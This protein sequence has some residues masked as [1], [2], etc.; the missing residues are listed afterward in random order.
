MGTTFANES[1]TLSAKVTDTVSKVHFDDGQFVEAGD[2]L[3]ELTDQEETALLAEANA[4]LADA[5]RQHARLADLLTKRS[6]PVSQVD[7]ALARVDAAEARYQSI[8]ARL[9]DRLVTAPFA[10]VLG[11]RQVSEG[12]LLTPSTPIATLDDV[13]VIK[14]DFSVPEVHLALLKPGQAVVATTPAFTDVTFP[15]R[16]LT[17][18]PRVDPVTRAA[19]IRALIA[20]PDRKLRPGM[21]MTVQLDLGESEALMIPETALTRAAGNTFVFLLRDGTAVRTG[22]ETARRS[23][24]WVE[25]VSGLSAGQQVI[26]AGVIKVRDGSAVRLEDHTAGAGSDSPARS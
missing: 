17:V 16:V 19:T 18:A 9:Q 4:N 6:V 14:L 12:T 2:V 21:L 11:F 5:R 15:A 13:D 22:V 1:V 20:N 25:V 24:G 3:V 8:V 10:G 23:D 26:T 7:E